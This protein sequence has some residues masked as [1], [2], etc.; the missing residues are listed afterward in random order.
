MGHAQKKKKRFFLPEMTSRLSAFRNFLFYQNIS[1]GWVMNLFLFC[2]MF[3]IEKGPL[4]AKTTE[5]V[6]EAV[7]V[8]FKVR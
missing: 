3:L 1:F 5:P 8:W 4:P 6:F 2:V 7:L